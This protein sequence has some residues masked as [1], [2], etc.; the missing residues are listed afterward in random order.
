MGKIY[1][2]EVFVNFRGVN[3]FII[4]DLSYIYIDKV[5]FFRSSFFFIVVCLWCFF[6]L[7]LVVYLIYF[8]VERVLIREVF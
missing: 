7:V 1:N 5:L 3:F 4:V 6:W 2:V 8:K